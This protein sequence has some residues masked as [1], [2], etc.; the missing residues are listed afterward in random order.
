MKIR[1]FIKPYC[2]WC[3]EA[4]DWLREREIK[5]DTLD[6]TN[7]PEAMNEMVRLTRQTKA[8]VIDVDGKILA[9]F[10]VTELE[11]FWN[12]LSEI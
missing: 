12:Q 10:D 6:V 9:D 11:Q 1:L 8:P 3:H 4:I 5:Y 7:D 2:G